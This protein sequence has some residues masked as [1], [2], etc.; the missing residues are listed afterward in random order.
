M[1]P[2]LVM[3]LTKRKAMLMVEMIKK[4][5]VVRIFV[6]MRGMVIWKNWVSRP[7]PSRLALSYRLMGTADMEAMYMTM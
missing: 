2:P 7:A 6:Q 3:A 1:G 5:R 4:V